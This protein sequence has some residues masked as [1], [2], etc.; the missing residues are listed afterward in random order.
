MI[1]RVHRRF[2]RCAVLAALIFSRAMP[3]QSPSP[4]SDAT[5]HV[6]STEVLVDV[7]VT[8]KNGNIPRDLTAQNFKILEDGQE[9][10]I[11]SFSFSGS[12]EPGRRAKRFMALVFDDDLPG[13]REAARRFVDENAG[14]DLYIA[15]YARTEKKV[16]AVLPFTSNAARIQAALNT[17]Q[18]GPLTPGAYLERNLSSP[19]MERVDRVAAEMA[20]IRGRK[21]MA[22]FSG[23]LATIGGTITRPNGTTATPGPP[24]TPLD[25]QMLQTI[26]DCKKANVMVFGFN[27]NPQIPDSVVSLAEDKN[28]RDQSDHVRGTNYIRDLAE[29]TGGRYGTP[30][31]NQLAAFLGK[32]VTEQSDYYVLG[33]T[34]AAGAASK[35]CHR[36]KVT[37]DRKGLDAGDEG[38]R[39][40][41]DG[42]KRVS[43]A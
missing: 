6:N 2:I 15:V 37:V 28:R 26:D 24:S 18:I 27:V 14:P 41:A 10:K 7:A 23:G 9:Q 1:D 30:S 33:Y 13:F 42:R 25:R 36:L 11:T 19:L 35:N 22:L 17:V 29:G 21:A 12:G 3:A 32:I 4:S 20:P 34:P 38:A 31:A 5:L 8:D 40:F 39:V 43:R 16:H